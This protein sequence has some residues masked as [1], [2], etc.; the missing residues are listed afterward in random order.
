MESNLCD[1]PSSYSRKEPVSS[2]IFKHFYTRGSIE[3]RYSF[4]HYYVHSRILQNV[5]RYRSILILFRIAKRS[6]V[7]F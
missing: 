4:F 2:V 7:I 1:R 5:A 6:F 3:W